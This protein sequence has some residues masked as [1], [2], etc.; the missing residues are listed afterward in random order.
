MCDEREQ[1]QSF[2]SEIVSHVFQIVDSFLYAAMI[3]SRCILLSARRREERTA[4]AALVKRAH[5]LTTIE[6]QMTRCLPSSKAK[7]N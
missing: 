2:E 7:F 1:Q 4:D 5:G 6:S 3:S